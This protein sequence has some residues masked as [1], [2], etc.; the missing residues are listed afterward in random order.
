MSMRKT[1]L[2]TG[3]HG[4]TGRYMRTELE[5]AGYRVIGLG[6]TPGTGADYRQV[7]L[8][9]VEGMEAALRDVRPDIV[10]HL[11]AVAFVDHSD[12]NAFYRVNLVG[13]RNLL[14]AMCAAGGT[15]SCV[16]LAS[17]ANVYGNSSEEKLDEDTPAAPVN[18]Y[19]VSKLAME[20][21]ARLY[22][23][24]LPLVVV[25]PFNYT[26]VGQADNFLVPKIVSCFRVGAPVIEL[27]NLDVWRDFGDVR[28]VV[29]AYRRLLEVPEARGRTFNVCSG[30]AYALR[31]IIDSC[32]HITGHR[33]QVRVNPRFVRADEV[34]RLWGDCD[35]LR[36]TIGNWQPLP[37][38]ETLR[39]MLKYPIEEKPQ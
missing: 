2:V 8:L 38:E 25:R 32:E 23:E 4:F 15:L 3:V 10:V 24:R 18:D 28:S 37:L 7:D 35:R 31:E 19:A 11:A 30:R 13:T 34:K 6:M 21:M 33:I 22:E 1:A 5:G 29:R 36:D 39:W 26:G 9:D 14:E 17:S 27:G 16:L 12:A 20:Y